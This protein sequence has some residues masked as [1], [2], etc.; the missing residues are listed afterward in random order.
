M[1]NPLEKAQALKSEVIE[2]KNNQDE[3][4]RKTRIS[5]TQNELSEEKSIKKDFSDKID[6][7]KERENQIRQELGV[8]KNERKQ[9]KEEGKAAANELRKDEPGQA[10]LNNPELRDK[11][12]GETIT[13]LKELRDAIKPNLAELKEI[14]QKINEEREKFRTAKQKRLNAFLS[15][16]PEIGKIQL[17]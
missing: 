4:A 2:E 5:K 15:E 3:L 12:F 14:S 7:A 9:S 6:E 11:V 10:I 1:P 8:L 13:R 17:S 16:H